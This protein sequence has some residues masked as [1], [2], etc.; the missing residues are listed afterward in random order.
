ME[1]IR[2]IQDIT[3]G[4]ILLFSIIFIVMALSIESLTGATSGMKELP[5][6]V[7]VMVCF[8]CFLGAVIFLSLGHQHK[9]LNK[10]LRKR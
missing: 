3:L 8:L 5:Q 7:F 6:S 1:K 10:N 9:S 2:L 4:I